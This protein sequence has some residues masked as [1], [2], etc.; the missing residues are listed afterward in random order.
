M[1]PQQFI[2]DCQR[3]FN[4]G[5]D[6]VEPTW[7]ELATVGEPVTDFSSVRNYGKMIVSPSIQ[8]MRLIGRS[9]AEKI[10]EVVAAMGQCVVHFLNGEER[11]RLEFSEEN[12]Q[13]VVRCYYDFGVEPGLAVSAKVVKQS[14]YEHAANGYGGP[15]K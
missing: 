14:R 10:N 9:G 15:I 1:I 4:E 6:S 2:D 11:P 13:V 8:G 5:F 7:K 12:G 3:A